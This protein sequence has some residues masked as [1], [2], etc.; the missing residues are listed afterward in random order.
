MGINL[1]YC[2]VLVFCIILLL[3]SS[4]IPL[5]TKKNGDSFEIRPGIFITARHIK[6]SI[7]RL[8]PEV[9]EEYLMRSLWKS[10]RVV[11]MYAWNSI[12]DELN[13]RGVSW[14]VI[15]DILKD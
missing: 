6:A 8:Y 3:M 10:D 5:F 12:I 13:D 9:C 7:L 1:C 14:I 15:D 11:R 2:F 4:K